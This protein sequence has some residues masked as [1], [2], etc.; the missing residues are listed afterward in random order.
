IVAVKNTGGYLLL[1]DACNEATIAELRKRKHRPAKPFAVLYPNL[2]LLR[3][4][5]Y[6]T[7]QMQ[8]ALESAAAPVVLSPLRKHTGHSIARHLL[9]PGLHTLGVMLPSSPLLQLIAE[10]FYGPLLATSGNLSGSPI[11]YRD[12]QA[13]MLL[14][15]VADY[16]LRYDRD[17]TMPQ[18]DS[19]CR[20]TNSGRQ[21]LLRRS[22]GLAPNYY[23]PPFPLPPAP[24]LAMGAELKNA[25]AISTGNNLFVS[26]YLG[27]QASLE[28]QES[29]QSCLQQL[30][31]L[32]QCIPEQIL[33]DP[34][35]GYGISAF[36]RKLAQDTGV[37]V[38]R[39]Q[40]HEAHFAAVLGENGLLDKNQP[41]LGCIWDGAGWGPDNQ[42][43][44]GELFYYRDYQFNRLG[45]FRYFPQLLGD[46][47]S[48]EPRLSALS[49]TAQCPALL[50]LLRS[51]FTDTEWRHYLQLLAHPEKLVHTSS[52]GR[53]TDAVA[54]LLGLA[55][56]CSYEGEAALLLESL[57]ASWQLPCYEY[58]PIPFVE[59][60][61]IWSVMLEEIA[62]DILLEQ[63]FAKIAWKYFHSLAQ[64]L[65]QVSDY[66]QIPAIACSGGV[67]QNALLTDLLLENAGD[68]QIYLHQQLSPNDECIGF[69]Q[70]ARYQC[71]LAQENLL[72][73]SE[74]L[75]SE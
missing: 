40:H 5:V 45:H 65:L 24:V 1:A 41:V 15:P 59:G 42:V 69:G 49:L 20:F 14:M 44:G 25:F 52:A 22:R 72:Q 27:D 48:R 30:Q 4:D 31:Q 12:K 18:D 33:I 55:M 6:L 50:P 17:I 75:Q 61:W 13:A 46:K 70:I 28:S 23:P 29:M 2:N 35:P 66:L 21:I 26:Q 43:W 32:L 38:T 74:A 57:A 67:F 73:V 11:L 36:G 8:D 54:A 58:Y 60:E 9:A 3:K 56:K 71:L 37:P 16:L 34:H 68:K 53:L 62:R 63:P 47:M 19:V 7:G 51:C 10:A 39:I 64:A